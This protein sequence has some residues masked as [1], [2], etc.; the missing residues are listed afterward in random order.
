M[1]WKKWI[2]LFFAGIFVLGALGC[3]P[4]QPFYLY[5]NGN[6]SAHLI[7]SQ[8][9]PELPDTRVPSLSEVEGAEV[10]LTLD[11]GTPREY[12]DLSLQDVIQIALQNGKVLRNLGGV[13]FGPT[14]AMGTPSVLISNPY[15]V[16]TIYDPALVESDPR[17]GVEAALSAFD[18]QL[19]AS[20]G[21][22]KTD[23]QINPGG[24]FA[25]IDTNQGDQG[26][27]RATISKY[28]ATGTTF[29]VRNN[30]IYDWSNSNAATRLH[31]SSWSA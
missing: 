8:M 28:A 21:W 19:S 14:G 24:I 11:D 15:A 13:S 16:G 10:P 31:G 4:Q 5:E 23:E 9:W 12:W 30:N 3:R 25:G 22:T 7:N 26:T 20:A 17:Y 18:G 27:F 1:S 6:T 29:Y 2:P